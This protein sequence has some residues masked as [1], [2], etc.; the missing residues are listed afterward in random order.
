MK[1]IVGLG[2]PG[3]KYL[4]QRHNVGFLAIDTLAKDLEIPLT[5]NRA[6]AVVGEGFIEGQ[7]IMLVK[8]QTFMNRSGDSV[9]PL[10]RRTG[11]EL[12]DVIILYDELDLPL[13][14]IRLRE[15]GSAA[16]HNGMRSIIA[17]LG[18]PEFPRLRIGIGRPEAAGRT[19]LQHVLG[20]FAAD[21]QDELDRT[22]DR[23]TEATKVLLRDGIRAAMNLYN[24]T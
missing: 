2:N 23:V 17:A 4:E 21:E 20:S 1:L 10:A 9:G 13:G 6:N 8:P 24:S 14:R 7:K 22:L 15:K 12:E 11:T 19:T 18:S 16:G 5:G 3:K